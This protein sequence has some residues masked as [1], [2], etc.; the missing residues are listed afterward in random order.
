MFVV[1]LAFGVAL[2]GCEDEG[3]DA[4]TE[5]G[6]QGGRRP[7]EEK[8]PAPGPGGDG[9]FQQGEED[10]LPPDQRK[11]DSDSSGDDD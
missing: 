10:R 4:A 1:L 9:G 8:R 7:K 11:D 5:F 2:P 6:A 3:A